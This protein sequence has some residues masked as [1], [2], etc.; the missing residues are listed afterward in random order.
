[1]TVCSGVRAVGVTTPSPPR[2]FTSLYAAV[3]SALVNAGGGGT[4]NWLA[5]CIKNGLHL[6]Q[7]APSAKGIK[8]MGS[9]RQWPGRL[10][11]DQSTPIAGSDISDPSVLIRRIVVAT[12]I[13]RSIPFAFRLESLT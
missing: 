11:V 5:D 7:C 8:L 13:P 1:M 2:P 9:W 4:R 3:Y 6:L 12:S 10:L